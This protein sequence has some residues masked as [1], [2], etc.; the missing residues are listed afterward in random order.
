MSLVWIHHT[1]RLHTIESIMTNDTIT[2]IILLNI[3]EYFGYFAFFLVPTFYFFIIYS[4]Y[5]FFLHDFSGTH[6]RTVRAGNYAPESIC[7]YPETGVP[8]SEDII[9][10]QPGR[11]TSSS[12]CRIILYII[13]SLIQ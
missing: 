6:V 3:S 12:I 7:L 10:L 4:F 8:C 13:L 5:N 2:Y 9:G 11:I 1:I